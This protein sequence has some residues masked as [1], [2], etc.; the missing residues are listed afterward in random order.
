MENVIIFLHGKGVTPTDPQYKEF[1][2]LARYYQADLIS[3]TAPNTHKDGFRWHNANKQ[4]IENAQKE[5]E[6]SIKHIESEMT[7][8]LAE[9]KISYQQV[10]WL[11]HSQG[12]DMAVRMALKYGAKKVIT[13]GGDI[14]PKFALPQRLNT[15]FHIDWVEAGHEDVLTKERCASFKILQ[16]MGIKVNYL[17]SPTSTHTCWNL[18]DYFD[19]LKRFS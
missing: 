4:P 16:K 9:R 10:I 18:N 15:A 1:E 13:F 14:S 17:V 7:K 3:I 12:A 8:I 6:N 5:F 11:G 19:F 2:E